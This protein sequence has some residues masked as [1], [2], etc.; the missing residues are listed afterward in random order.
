MADAPPPPPPSED[1]P[2][3]YSAPSAGGA[4][5]SALTASAV[6]LFVLGGLS[7]LGGLLLLA[8][9]GFLAGDT[10]GGL[11]TTL[12]IIALALGALDI[13][14]GVKILGLQRI[15]RTLGLV[16]GIIGVVFSLLSIANSPLISIIYLALYGFVVYSL[17]Q[18]ASYFHD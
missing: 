11:L 2:A 3:P 8:G 15:G 13:F 4:R 9:G 14:A 16:A 18:N 1:R 17:Y 6:I 12:G 5:P 7:V 10:S